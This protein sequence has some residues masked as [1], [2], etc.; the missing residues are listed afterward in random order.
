MSKVILNITL[1]LL[2][3]GCISVKKVTE[4]QHLPCSSET[5]IEKILKSKNS[6]WIETADT[7]LVFSAIDIQS[8]ICYGSLWSRQYSVNFKFDSENSELKIE[9]TIYSD[10]IIHSILAGDTLSIKL[11]EKEQKSLL[12]GSLVN[13][14][15]YV[16]RQKLFNFKFNEFFSSLREIH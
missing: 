4:Y 1:F 14:T 12:G 8:A 6:E 16:H 7:L 10:F 2:I 13:V 5:V 15:I 11:K 3:A 9:P